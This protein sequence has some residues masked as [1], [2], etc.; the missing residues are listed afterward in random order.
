MSRLDSF[1]RRLQAQREVLDWATREVAGVPGLVLEIGLG[2]GRT[3]SHLR[4]RLP[5]RDIYAFDR[6]DNAHPDSKPAGEQLVLGEFRD[7]LPA[8]GARHPHAACLIHL[9]TGS[10]DAA[11]NAR[12][13]EWLSGVVPSLAA[14]G[15]I[16][17]SDQALAHQMLRETAAPVDIPERRYFI[18]VADRR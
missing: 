14:T 6:V 1:I 10:G 11:A 12:Q 7:T 2:N 15:A 18:Y 5:G 4:E 17:L 3:F 13:A 9:D 16:V 8:F